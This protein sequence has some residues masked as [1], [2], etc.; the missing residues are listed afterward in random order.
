MAWL[1]NFIRLSYNLDFFSTLILI[2]LALITLRGFSDKLEKLISL[3][4]HF[5]EFNMYTYHIFSPTDPKYPSHDYII[6]EDYRFTTYELRRKVLSMSVPNTL[7]KWK[8]DEK[9]IKDYFCKNISKLTTDLKSKDLK[10]VRVEWIHNRSEIKS[11]KVS[12]KC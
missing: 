3:P 8:V 1:K 2:F 9:I 6:N 10:T 12:F 11:K 4:A 5:Y 7:N